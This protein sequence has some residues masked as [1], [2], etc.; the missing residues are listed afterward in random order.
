MTSGMIRIAEEDPTTPDVVALLEA[1]LA[2]SLE[3]TPPEDVYAMGPEAVAAEQLVV[4]GAREN[5]ALVGIGAVRE[6]DT[7]TGE[8][9]SMH[10]ASAARGRGV[11]RLIL[12]DLLHRCRARGYS[13]VLLETGSMPEMAPARALYERAGFVR[14]AP[15]GRYTDNGINLCYELRLAP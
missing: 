15:Y 9:K 6:I 2:F 7:R 14:C 12:D 10:T 3:V 5:G 1:H 13:R 4:I 8:V 11:A